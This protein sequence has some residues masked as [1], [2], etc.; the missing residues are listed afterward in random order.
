MQTVTNQI[1]NSMA[2]SS[3]IRRMFE[4]GLELKKEFG[5]EAVCDFSLGNPD[6]PPPG[7]TR[8]VLKELSEAAVRPLGLGYCP[9]AGI[10]QVRAAMA[11]LL[12]TQQKTA[13]DASHVVMTVGAAGA[14]VAFFRAVIESGDEVITPA[15]YFVEYG[16]YCGHFGGVLKPVP[17]LPPSF[18]LDVPAIA[19]AITPRTRAIILNSP[20][21]PTGCIYSEEDLKAVA[22][23]VEAENARRE[24]SGGEARAL[25]ILSDEPYRAFAYDGAEVPAM[26]PI[27]KWALVFGSFSKTLSLAGERVGYFLANPAMPDVATLV[28]AVTLTN[29]TLGFVN[30]PVIGQRLAAALKDETVDLEIYDRRRRLM[31]KVLRDA[32]VEFEMPKGAFYFFAKS[33]VPD[34]TL[35]VDALLRER[36]LVVP[37]RGFG[38]AGYVRLSCSVDEAIISRSAEGF[39]RAVQSLKA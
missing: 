13:V 22:A 35:F 26:L 36:I 24:A 14:L 32:G 25:F 6:V 15:P 2:S 27:S 37:G 28:A 9:N 7:R 17:S 10:P 31:A 1:R 4:K 21:N 34:D 12:G 3:W 5:E 20:N 39:R 29:R 16:A 18:R 23:V 11:E 8:E 33:P 38:F 19:A 30:A